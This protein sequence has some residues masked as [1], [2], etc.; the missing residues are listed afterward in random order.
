MIAIA[1]T[2]RRGRIHM[3]DRVQHIIVQRHDA[4]ICGHYIIVRMEICRVWRGSDRYRIAEDTKRD[5]AS[6]GN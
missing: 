4:V 2:V 5:I 1:Y 3:E 6:G